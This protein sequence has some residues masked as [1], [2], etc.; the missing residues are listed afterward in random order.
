MLEQKRWHSHALWNFAGHTSVPTVQVP[1]GNWALSC[2]VN[3]I[4]DKNAI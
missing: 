4:A 1:A 2:V 3:A